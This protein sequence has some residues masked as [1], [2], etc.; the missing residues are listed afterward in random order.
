MLVNESDTAIVLKKN[1]K[2]ADVFVYNHEYDVEQV[3]AELA[4][5]NEV[6]HV[7]SGSIQNEITNGRQSENSEIKFKFGEAETTHPERCRHFQT[8]LPSLKDAF[9][10]GEFDIGRSTTGDLFDIEL[11]SGPDIRERPRPIPPSDFEEC[12]QHIKGLLDA[13]IIRPSN[14]PFASPIVLVRKKS[15]ALRMCIDYRKLNARTVKDSYSIPKIEDLLLTLNGAKY[16]STFDLCKAYYQ[17]PMTEQ[18]SRYSAFITP[19]GLFEWDRLSQGLA[20]APACFQRLMETVFSD[21]NLTQL[22]IFLDDIHIHAK[23][24]QELEERTV[25]VLE[26]LC[27]YNLKLDPTKCV[28]GATEV[29]HLGYV[30]SEGTIK[31]DPEKVATV[32]NWPRPET[33]RD[34]KKFIGFAGF[35]RRFIPCFSSLARPLNDLTIGY[36]PGGRSKSGRK[37]KG[38][39]SLTSSITSSWGEA[40][41]KAFQSLK[42]DRCTD[43]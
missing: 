3:I 9:V 24:P 35:Y 30:I 34:V 11:E 40:Q 41:E 43:E 16:F 29:K 5:Q 15:G 20:N 22:I 39:L 7:F 8:R 6:S 19:F 42:F 32:K 25:R 36:A 33:V 38:Q 17:V 27:K 13:K 1:Q 37:A 28:F 2:I 21:M 18:A 10:T 4:P 14:S 12:R 26:R 23:S 31:P